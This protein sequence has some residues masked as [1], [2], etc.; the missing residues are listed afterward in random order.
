[1]LVLAY[2]VKVM[3]VEKLLMALYR[4]ITVGE[5]G[6]QELLVYPQ[7]IRILVMA[8]RVLLQLF[9]EL[10]QLMLEEVARVVIL[11]LAALLVLE[12]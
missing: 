9:Q 1:V 7:I 2:L 6:V 3:Q 10:L 12:A 5:A 8:V 11:V 4:H